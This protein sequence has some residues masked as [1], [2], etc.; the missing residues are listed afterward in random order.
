VSTHRA[1]VEA[2]GRLAVGT[3]L[4][5]GAAMASFR[6]AALPYTRRDCLLLDGGLSGRRL[7]PI[8]SLHRL[9]CR[10]AVFVMVEDQAGEHIVEIKQDIHPCVID[11]AK[12]P[13]LGSNVGDLALQITRRYSGTGGRL[14]LL[15]HTL[16]PGDRF[17]LF[18]DVPPGLI[19]APQALC[20]LE[21]AGRPQAIDRRLS[22][23]SECPDMEYSYI[24]T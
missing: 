16:L 1:D 17:L 5:A 6:G 9:C 21:G 2:R 13:I 23:G 14:L 11:A 4:P 15:S 10:T 22:S 20:P 7:A 24:R 3:R 12:A 19:A 18:D 8:V